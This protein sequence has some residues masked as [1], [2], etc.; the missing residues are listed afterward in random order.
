MKKYFTKEGA[1]VIPGKGV[2][3][4]MSNDEICELITS[5]YVSKEVIDYLVKAGAIV[6]KNIDETPTS[7]EYYV[8]KLKERFDFDTNTTKVMLYRFKDKCPI[9]AFQLL[10]K[11]VAIELDKKYDGHIIDS[12]TLFIIDAATGNIVKYIAPEDGIYTDNISLFRT[13]KDAKIAIS[14]L[15]EFYDTC[16]D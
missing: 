8:N 12:D 14:I 3:V 5:S 16:F 2:Y 10:L 1:E 13:E 4:T 7:V 6:E 11:Q 15:K 9:I